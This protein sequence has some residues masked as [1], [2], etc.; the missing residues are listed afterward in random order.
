M[1]DKLVSEKDSY[2]PDQIVAIDSSGQTY[3]W[4][5]LQI[6]MIVHFT[7]AFKAQGYPDA[8]G[9]S[10]DENNVKF[11]PS[12]KNIPKEVIQK[13]I[14]MTMQYFYSNFIPYTE[15]SKDLYED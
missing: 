5:T 4:S 8:M 7:E 11:S 3:T 13:S 14:D 6:I 10:L 12:F 15:T 2:T 9:Y 1:L